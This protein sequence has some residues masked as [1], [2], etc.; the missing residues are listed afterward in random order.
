MQFITPLSDLQN[1]AVTSSIMMSAGR[2]QHRCLQSPEVE[3]NCLPLFSLSPGLWS[4]PR[5]LPGLSDA[6]GFELKVVQTPPGTSVYC[7]STQEL[8]CQSVIV[9]L[10]RTV[11]ERLYSHSVLIKFECSFTP[12]TDE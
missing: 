4:R 9:K 3:I 11:T 6:P 12:R 7:A 1:T 10:V 2:H 8:V 5:R